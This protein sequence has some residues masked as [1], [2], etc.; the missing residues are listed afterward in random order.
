MKTFLLAALLAAFFVSPA[1]AEPIS[2]IIASTMFPGLT[3][4]ALGI[5]SS[6]LP[7]GVTATIHLFRKAR[8]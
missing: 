1:S 6:A 4:T 7:L 5:V 8:P 2:M 3:G